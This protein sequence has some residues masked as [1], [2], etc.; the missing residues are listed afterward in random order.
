MIELM[1]TDLIHLVKPNLREKHNQF[2]AAEMLK[3]VYWQDAGMDRK[4]GKKSLMLRQFEEKYLAQIIAQAELMKDK[5]L[6]QLLSKITVSDELKTALRR[7]DYVFNVKW[8]LSHLRT[9]EHYLISEGQKTAS[10]GMSDWQK[11]LH[12]NY[13]RRLFFP[14]LWSKEEL[15]NWGNFEVE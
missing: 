5:N 3:D 15:E 4:T 6:F 11:Y 2:N 8:P 1:C 13:Q 9:A 14:T 12:P 7:M 10:T